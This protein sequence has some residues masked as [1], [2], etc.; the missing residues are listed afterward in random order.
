VSLTGSGEAR[1]CIL[2]LTPCF[3]FC[4]SPWIR[5][6]TLSPPHNSRIPLMLQALVPYFL[7][8]ILPDC[9]FRLFLSGSTQFP[10]LAAFI[11]NVSTFQLLKCL[12]APSIPL[13]PTHTTTHHLALL[14]SQFG[15]FLSPFSFLVGPDRSFGFSPL[16]SPFLVLTPQSPTVG[17]HVPLLLLHLLLRPAQSSHHDQGIQA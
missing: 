14:L 10:F 8:F 3:Q 1:D 7:R 13:T 5:P 4:R 2:P 15:L 9:P 12:A 17:T 6:A 11:S 16:H